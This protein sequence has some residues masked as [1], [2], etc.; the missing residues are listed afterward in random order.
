MQGYVR[1]RLGRLG[2]FD[3][4]S[5]QKP[6]S[7]VEREGMKRGVMW[8]FV[9]CGLKHLAQLRLQGKTS[10]SSWE[11]ISGVTTLPLWPM[12]HHGSPARPGQGYGEMPGRLTERSC[13]ILCMCPGR[14]QGESNNLICFERVGGGQHYRKLINQ[15]ES[16]G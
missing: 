12:A 2:G 9:A 3:P 11:M 16:I 10:L 8:N 13:M 14:S 6:A 15:H 4:H 5:G 7:H 1:F